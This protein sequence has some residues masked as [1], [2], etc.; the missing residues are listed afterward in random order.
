MAESR[1]VA[2]LIDYKPASI[3]CQI[4]RC[5]KPKQIGALEALL[6]TPPTSYG[7]I[8]SYQLAFSMSVMS[9]N[10]SVIIISPLKS[11]IK[12]K[13]MEM[14]VLE[15]SPVHLSRNKEKI[16]TDIAVEF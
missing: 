9:L 4:I 3:S 11:I 12:E 14:I 15:I 10:Y 7:E 13:V 6:V 1:V 8:F 5:L 16:L 2:R